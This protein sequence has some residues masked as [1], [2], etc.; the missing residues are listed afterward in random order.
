MADK[1]YF[2]VNVENI[3]NNRFILDKAES[4]HLLKVLRKPL[5]TDIW[6][7]DGVGTTYWGR[8]KTIENDIAQGEILKVYP[9]YGENK[10][11]IFLGIGIL[12]KDKMNLVVE[13]ATEGGVTEIFPLKLDKCIKQNIQIERLQK[14]SQTA[15]KQCGRSVT[16]IIHDQSNLIDTLVKHKEALTMACH[17]SGKIGVNSIANDIK[18]YSKVLLLIGPEGDFS[19]R[20]LDMLNKNNSI[21][22]N[23]GNRRLRSETAVITAISQLNS[24]CN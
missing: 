18:N 15:V 12:K 2:F 11:Q 19:E 1:I 3:S 21:F 20:E 16:P 5:G 7:T 14:I 23:L 13:K 4:H 17:E 8:L 10:I 24:Y 22:I 6:L 9:K